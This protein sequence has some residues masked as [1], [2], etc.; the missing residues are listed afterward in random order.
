MKRIKLTDIGIE[1]R[2]NGR[3][4]M[5]LL[6]ISSDLAA[7]WKELMQTCSWQHILRNQCAFISRYIKAGLD[8]N[9]PDEEGATLLHESACWGRHSA[10][11][12]LL[13]NGADVDSRMERNKTPLHEATIN[14]H[15][16]V[17]RTLLDNGAEVDARTSS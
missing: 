11:E 3:V 14:N 1:S 16:K 15:G 7:E 13:K 10:V 2:V 9:L 12:L 6:E 4:T 5:R 17:M 8:V